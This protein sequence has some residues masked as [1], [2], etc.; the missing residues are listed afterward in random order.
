MSNFSNRI[1]VRLGGRRPLTIRFVKKRG[2]VQIMDDCHYS[3]EILLQD[4]LDNCSVNSLH[5]IFD[6]ILR[7]AVA[8][9]ER[10]RQ[11]LAATQRARIKKRDGYCCRY[12]G[13]KGSGRWGPDKRSWHVDHVIAQIHGGTDDDEN[14]VLACATCNVAKHAKDLEDFEAEAQLRSLR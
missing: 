2:V 13:R 10:D 14:L 11:Q 6:P 5:E 12:C 9:Q 8:R 7:I 1:E 3:A 4:L